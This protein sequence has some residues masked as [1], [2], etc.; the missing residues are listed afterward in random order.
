MGKIN[1]I[2]RKSGLNK[3]VNKLSKQVQRLVVAKERKLHYVT[4]SAT[5]WNGAD[6]SYA[7]LL[8]NIAVG[9]TLAEREGSSIQASRIAGYVKFSNNVLSP[10]GTYRF[11]ILQTKKQAGLTATT[12]GQAF[13]QDGVMRT[14][15]QLA[16]HRIL[17]DSGFKTMNDSGSGSQQVRVH[18]FN[19]SVPKSALLKYLGDAGTTG[20]Q[21][22]ISLVC[23]GY[24]PTNGSLNAWRIAGAVHLLFNE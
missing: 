16:D 2:P 22:Q 14:D 23:V 7:P 4:L 3:K 19:V 18:K 17:Y 10:N 11:C 13:G 15:T 12:F 21:G 9:D 5:S 1:R 8:T 20:T 6:S 24:S